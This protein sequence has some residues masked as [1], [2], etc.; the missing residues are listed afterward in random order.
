MRCLGVAGVAAAL[1]LAT[2]APHAVA[3]GPVTPAA[4]AVVF[5]GQEGPKVLMAKDAATAAVTQQLL[6]ALALT[7]NAFVQGTDIAAGASIAAAAPAN[8]SSATV[9]SVMGSIMAASILDVVASRTLGDP[10][11]F[12]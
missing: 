9:A 6:S 2:L 10:R 5:N 11:V 8:V 7:A 12:P 3:L 4:P 1:V